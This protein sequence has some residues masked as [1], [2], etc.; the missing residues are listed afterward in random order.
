MTRNI[1]IRA[2]LQKSIPA[3][4]MKGKELH[5]IPGQPPDPLHPLP[6]CPFAPR[7]SYVD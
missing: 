4:Q 6:G 7:C 5:T 3:L 1:L 2:A